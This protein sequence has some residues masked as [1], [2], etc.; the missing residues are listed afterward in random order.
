MTRA[1]W[2]GRAFPLGPDWDGQGTNFSI[3][4]ERAEAVDGPA[5]LVD[6]EEGRGAGRACGRRN[7]SQR[8][9]QLDNLRRRLKVSSEE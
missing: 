5:L 8:L 9:Q 7:S 4:S 6:E 1:V 2:P 3:F